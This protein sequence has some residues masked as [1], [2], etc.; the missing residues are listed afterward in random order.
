MNLLPLE[1]ID[2]IV[3][4]VDPKDYT[5]YILAFDKGLEIWYNKD[6]RKKYK[7][8]YL[9]Y[10]ETF[11]ESYYVRKDNNK[12]HGT[13]LGYYNNRL[14]CVIS[15]INGKK[16]GKCMSYHKN[17]HLWQCG[18]YDTNKM[19]GRYLEYYE[20]GQLRYMID[21]VNN[22][23]HGK[24]LEYNRNGYLFRDID[25]V[26]NMKHGKY[27]EYHDNCQFHYITNYVNGKKYGERTVCY[28]NGRLWFK[29]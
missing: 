27:L 9:T 23:K 25:Y 5:N 19:N 14:K 10:I 20:N 26:N 13:Y 28:K 1:I 7:E 18:Y 24:Y 15:Y 21:N 12:N 11:N 6:L 29:L 17:G 22:M 16:H 8:Q 3:S 2:Y 4:K